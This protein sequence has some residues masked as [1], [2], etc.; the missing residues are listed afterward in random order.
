MFERLNQFHHFFIQILFCSVSLT[1]RTWRDDSLAAKVQWKCIDKPSWPVVVALNL[2]VGTANQKTKNR[3]SHTEKQCVRTFCFVMWSSPLETALSLPLNTRSSCPSR[4][5]ARKP[6]VLLIFSFI[7]I[8]CKFISLLS[9]C[10]WIWAHLRFFIV[11]LISK[12]IHMCKDKHAN[13]LWVKIFFLWLLFFDHTH[14]HTCFSK[15]TVSLPEIYAF[16]VQFVEFK[17]DS[18]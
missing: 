3:S 8:P 4:T 7:Y 9:L 12:L 14:T 15:F 16:W 10:K 17:V 6:L 13:I 2:I 18:N 5:I 1:T 11:F